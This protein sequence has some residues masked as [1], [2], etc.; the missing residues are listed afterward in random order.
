[1]FPPQTWRDT[2]WCG[3]ETATS[4]TSSVFQTP[5]THFTF[6]PTSFRFISYNK[7]TLFYGFDLWD[8]MCLVSIVMVLVVP[9]LFGCVFSTILVV[10][11]YISFCMYHLPKWHMMGVHVWDSQ[12]SVFIIVLEW[13]LTP[14][15]LVFRYSVVNKLLQCISVASVRYQITV[16]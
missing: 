11:P 14:P 4:Y 7:H 10:P 8:R 1:M 2:C 13:H 9:S 12:V 3:S 6:S 16:N 15:D 5:G